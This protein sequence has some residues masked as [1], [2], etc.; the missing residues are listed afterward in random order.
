[1]IVLYLRGLGYYKYSSS[2]HQLKKVL[3][4]CLAIING[5]IKVSS[6]SIFNVVGFNLLRNGEKCFRIYCYVFI[7]REPFL[8]YNWHL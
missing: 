7:F 3:L 5:N 4:K 6:A 1:M 2:Q 8:T